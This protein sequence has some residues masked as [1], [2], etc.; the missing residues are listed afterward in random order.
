MRPEP[1]PHPGEQEPRNHPVPVIDI[2]P[3]RDGS[4]PAGVAQALHRASREVGFLYVVN[5][6][7][8]LT[9][10]AE[11]RAQ[12]LQFF[13]QSDA[14]KQAV[15]ISSR[16]RGF[17][18]QGKARMHGNAL[19]DLKESFVWGYE[20]EHGHTPEDHALRGAN[21]WPP[22]MPMLRQSALAFY[23]QADQ[24]ARHLLRGFATGLGL[25]P[26]YFLTQSTQPM[27]RAAFVYYPPQPASVGNVGYG[28]APHTDFGVLTVLCQDDVGGLEVQDA[29]GVWVA[30]PPI[31]GTLVVNVGDLLARWTRNVYRSTPHRVVNRS[32]RE[33]L[34][35]VLA[36]DPD[37]D[38]LVDP[39]QVFGHADP[40]DDP[41]TCGDYLE[42]RFGKSFDY[43]SKHLVTDAVRA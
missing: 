18:E 42:W 24:V 16:H 22:A 41:I 37:P 8:D 31:A 20:N 6:G 40:A 21:R 2:G 10:L 12:A 34:S 14:A 32:G 29:D 27:S 19:P 30:A 4:D 38:T 23:K 25:D 35:L 39:Q 36:F 43:R 1:E 33:R 3:L 11:A 15:G 26:G 9:L 5:H 28:V 7:I 17:L 13:R